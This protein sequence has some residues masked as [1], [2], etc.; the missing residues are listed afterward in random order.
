M[1][2][3]YITAGI[4]FVV[5]TAA[6]GLVVPLAG[7]APTGSMI[8]AAAG[9]ELR[10]TFDNGESLRAG[11]VVRD[12]SGHRNRGRVVVAPR[13]RIAPDRGIVKR[14]ADYPAKGRAII[15]SR[16]RRSL[17]PRRKSFRFG[18]AIKVTS[19]QARAES[20]II[21][22]GFFLQ[23]GGQ[24]KLQLDG[25]GSPSCVVNGSRGRVITHSL[26]SVA[27]GRWHRLECRRTPGAVSV[28]VDGKR[29]GRVFGSTGVV[30]NDAP[31]RV[32][33]S[34]IA[35]GNDQFRGDLDSVFVDVNR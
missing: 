16:D 21:Q 4:A 2:M 29:R 30:A 18:A 32:G 33:G 23:P 11:T 20:N 5:A 13:G 19:R 12:V 1:R 3:R 9:N 10:F 31:V 35:R 34:K 27:D 14:G 28:W 15:E 24:W 26:V 22:K 17:D 6:P 7:G 8:Q 25:N